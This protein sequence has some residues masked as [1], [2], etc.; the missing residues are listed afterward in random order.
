MLKVLLAT[1][2]PMFLSLARARL[3]DA[4]IDLGAHHARTLDQSQCQA[5]YY[6]IQARDKNQM[7]KLLKELMLCVCELNVN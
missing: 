3:L 2:S 1:K 4:L 5:T 6:T 7:V